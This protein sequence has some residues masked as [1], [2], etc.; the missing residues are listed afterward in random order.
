MAWLFLMRRLERP[1]LH[2]CHF[3][4]VGHVEVGAMNRP[5]F[6]ALDALNDVI[7]IRFRIGVKRGDFII[8]FQ[9]F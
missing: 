5:G 2:F 7:F 3:N 9:V 1:E 6:E 4:D 8:R